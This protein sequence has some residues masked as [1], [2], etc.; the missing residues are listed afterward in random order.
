MNCAIPCFANTLVIAAVSVVFPWS[1]CPIVPTF[2]CGF[3][4]SNFS[5]LILLL[6]Q[7]S[8]FPGLNWRPHPYQGCALPTELK[9][10]VSLL[11]APPHRW[12]GKRDSNPRHSAWK[13]DAL[14]SELFPPK[15]LG[16]GGWIRTNEGVEPADLQ[17]APFGRSG[18]PPSSALD[19]LHPIFF[20][21]RALRPRPP[22]LAG[23]GFEP[24]TYGLQI[25]CSTN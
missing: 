12:S 18:T 22:F 2:T 6:C 13:A 8:P 16:G 11:T 20:S 4:L 19:D 14:P 17:S 21:G 9:G 24:A 5:L 23:G 25:R 3:V 15:V 7:W 10:P 1:T